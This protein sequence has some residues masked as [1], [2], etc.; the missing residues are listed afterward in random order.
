MTCFV[1]RR[2][3]CKRSTQFVGKPTPEDLLDA[4]PQPPAE[5]VRQINETVGGRSATTT[6][7]RLN[8]A[9]DPTMNASE[10]LDLMEEFDVVPQHL[11]RSDVSQLFQC[12]LFGAM[13][14]EP[15]SKL[16][17]AQM[18]PQE[19]RYPQF[20][21]LLIRVAVA[22][23]AAG[24]QQDSA[25]DRGVAVG[26]AGLPVVADR[27]SVDGSSA[28]ERLMSHLGLVNAH[29][30]ELKHRLDALARV[31]KELG[32]KKK[33]NKTMYVSSK[34][35]RAQGSNLMGSIAA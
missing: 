5:L 26:P 11:S 16:S 2:W 12:V 20:K 8:H 30:V 18:Q 22:M 1:N 3:Y 23:A 4:P 35:S 33:G 7:R 29:V 19:I 14:R 34:V 15:P 31:A 13:R 21:D 10:F 6:G 32:A 25:R 24:D 17:R 28:V 9:P 27:P